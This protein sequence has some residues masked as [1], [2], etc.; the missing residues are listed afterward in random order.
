MI[1][2]LFAFRPIHY[3]L[4]SMADDQVA[5]DLHIVFAVALTGYEGSIW[6]VSPAHHGSL[7]H[8]CCIELAFCTANLRPFGSHVETYA[9]PWIELYFHLL[10]SYIPFPFQLVEISEATFGSGLSRQIRH[11]IV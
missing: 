2:V 1:C 8:T 5:S 10:F 7:W 4:Y 3:L 9:Y 6:F 11:E